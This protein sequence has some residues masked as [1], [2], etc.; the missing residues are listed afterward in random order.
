MYI[1]YC[2]LVSIWQRDVRE[3]TALFPVNLQWIYSVRVQSKESKDKSEIILVWE[4]M[5]KRHWLYHS[6][7]IRLWQIRQHTYSTLTHT[8]VINDHLRV[9]IIN[10]ESVNKLNRQTSKRLHS[11]K[12][13]AQMKDGGVPHF[14]PFLTFLLGSICS[15]HTHRVCLVMSVTAFWQ[16][17]SNC[18]WIH[19]QI[20]DI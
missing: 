4:E 20:Q 16:K 18:K 15:K 1:H 17:S 11:F 14:P 2:I 19:G 3:W 7:L 8:P 9:T 5:F 10:D 12:I 6:P 13:R